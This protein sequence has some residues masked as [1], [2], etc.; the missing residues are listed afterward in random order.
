[1]D[2]L[3]GVLWAEAVCLSPIARHCG[4]MVGG[5]ALSSVHWSD[6]P[7]MPDPVRCGSSYGGMRAF[8][9]WRH[10][11]RCMFD[12]RGEP[13]L[14]RGDDAGVLTPRIQELG[15]VHDVGAPAA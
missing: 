4:G 14:G 10:A 8:F 13:R 2:L 5:A 9:C 11:G 7:V 12:R 6:A 3:R 1:M 15:P